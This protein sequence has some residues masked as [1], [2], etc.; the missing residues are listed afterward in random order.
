M[1]L[2]A[3]E[4]GSADLV[5]IV[6]QILKSR[7]FPPGLLEMEVTETAAMAQSDVASVAVAA[8][9][10]LG[11][12]VALDDFGTGYSSLSHLQG[13]WPVQRLKIDRAFIKDLPADLDSTA[14]AGAVISLAHSLGIVGPRG[15]RRDGR[16]TGV[17]PR[18][19]L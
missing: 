4:L 6:A 14:I 11:V 13:V 1:N 16:A 10:S 2:S 7:D 15:R 3:R 17:P 9:K 8:L 12:T 5:E 19:G 18:A